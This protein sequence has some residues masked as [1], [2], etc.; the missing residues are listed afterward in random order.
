[1]V[2]TQPKSAPSLSEG[3]TTEWLD[4]SY[5]SI[6]KDTMVA[7]REYTLT[8]SV[9]VAGV[10]GGCQGTAERLVLTNVPPRAIDGISFAPAAGWGG[11]G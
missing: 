5:F 6:V 9:R 8:L 2:D 1:L 7:G 4:K 10:V 11:A 3:A